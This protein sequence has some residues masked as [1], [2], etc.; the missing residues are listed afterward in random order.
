[1]TNPVN[2]EPAPWQGLRTFIVDRKVR[3]CASISSFYLIPEDGGGLPSFEPGQFLTLEL[4]IPGQPAPVRRSYSLSDAPGRDY[5]RLTIK[6][7]S[8]PET[9][10][11]AAPG[12]ASNYLVGHVQAGDPLRVG[13]P[14]GDFFLRDQDERPVVLLCGG[15]GLTPV[16]SMLNAMVESGSAKKPIWFIHGVRNGHDHAMGGHIKRVTAE[17]ANVH[18]HICYSRPE[19]SESAA[20]DFDTAGRVNPDLLKRVLPGS[21]CEFYLCGP[22]PFMKS[23]FRGLLDWGVQAGRIHYEFFGPSQPLLD[24]GDKTS[25]EGK[26]ARQGGAAAAHRVTFRNAEMEINWD[27]EFENIL[28]FAE[29]QGMF[30]PFNC[31]TGICTTCMCRLLEGEVEYVEEPLTEPDPGC[32]LICCSRPKTDIVLDL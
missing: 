4:E 23:L 17:R 22:T 19:A 30:P 20:R 32:V 24:H 6:Q 21:D 28:D 1:M 8:P 29:A 18:A 10:P 26:P 2:T 12:L 16:L 9:R 7:L 5:Y 11:D 15:V 31:R 25:A 27:P 14:A 3:E 13:A